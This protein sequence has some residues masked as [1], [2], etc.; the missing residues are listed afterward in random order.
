MVDLRDAIHSTPTRAVQEREQLWQSRAI[1][2]SELV[3]IGP[4]GD[5][6]YLAR[7]GQSAWEDS[8][9]KGNINDPGI[10]GSLTITL[11]TIATVV[12]LRS[13]YKRFKRVEKRRLESEEN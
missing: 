13:F 9:M 8:S 6:E 5:V 10:A 4:R 2:S 3:H 7:D 12:L 1:A 11:L